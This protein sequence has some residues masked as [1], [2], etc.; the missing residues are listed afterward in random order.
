MA[1]GL[2]VTAVALCELNQLLVFATGAGYQD[3]GVLG[4]GCLYNSLHLVMAQCLSNAGHFAVCLAAD[5]ADAA[6]LS[7]LV[8]GCFDLIV[9]NKL[10]FAGGLDLYVLCYIVTIGA[11]LILQTSCAAGCCLGHGYYQTGVLGFDCIIA[12]FSL[13]QFAG[14]LADAF[15]LASGLAEGL[16]QCRLMSVCYLFDLLTFCQ[17]CLTYGADLLAFPTSGGAG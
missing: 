12:Q 1:G 8:A 17:N 4:A 5:R 9:I 10:V 7:C 3:A 2:F 13:A 6:Y 16:Y 15:G 14:I 11:L